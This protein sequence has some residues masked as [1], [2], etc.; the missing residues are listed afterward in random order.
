MRT[1][2]VIYARGEGELVDEQ[3]AA[4]Q[5][6]CARRKYRVIALARDRPGELHAWESAQQ[7]LR[8]GEADRV[9]VASGSDLPDILESATGGLPGPAEMRQLRQPSR[10]I[11][12][13]RRDG[14]A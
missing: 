7:M 12:P 13:T 6:L 8:D 5:E 1:K 11:R 9:I 4:C 14:G 10:R 3:L 2:I